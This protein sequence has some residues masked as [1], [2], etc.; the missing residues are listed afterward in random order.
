[1]KSLFP[2]LRRLFL[3]GLL[4][5]L[6]SA[7]LAA[8]I[9]RP[10]ALPPPPAGAPGRAPGNANPAAATSVTRAAV[11]VTPAPAPVAAEA[12]SSPGGAGAAVMTAQSMSGLD[13]SRSLGIGDRL[14]YRVIEDKDK[15]YTMI[16]T[17]SG[18][19]DVPYYGRVQAKGKTCLALANA[20]KSKLEVDLYYKATV[21]V[22]LDSIG[23]KAPT[24]SAGRVY[25]TGSVRGPGPVE[26]P[27]D[28][29]LTV[30][31]AILRAGGF[32]DFGNQR[33][34]YLYR[35]GKGSQTETSVIDVKA[36]FE[37]KLDRDMELK[38]GDTI[39]VPEKAFNIG[40]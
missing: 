3:P 20:I 30:S 21:L 2:A 4:V 22:A 31:K 32:A 19:V 12:P 9:V 34:V 27:S 16:V 13:N 39:R 11:P 18:E 38:D 7:P 37:G 25:V 28:E 1:M 6:S 24:T 5:A 10:P 33:K 29:K 40:F 35:K 17:D 23:P 26:M 15:P 14:S 8:Q 36:I